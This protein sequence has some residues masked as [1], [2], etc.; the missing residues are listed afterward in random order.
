MPRITNIPLKKGSSVK[1]PLCK[2]K[3]KVILSNVNGKET[4][5]LMCI[6]CPNKDIPKTILV[7]MSGYK[8][9]FKK[10]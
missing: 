6:V 10:G 2:K 4:D 3:H 9:E 1:C 5:D 8:I 7:G